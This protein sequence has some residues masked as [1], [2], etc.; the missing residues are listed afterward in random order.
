VILAMMESPNLDEWSDQLDGP[1]WD[2]PVK[3]RERLD[4]DPIERFERHQRKE[5][6]I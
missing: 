1:R 6:L 2:R 5:A 3:Q 4:W